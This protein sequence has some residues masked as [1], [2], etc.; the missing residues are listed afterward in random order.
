MANSIKT[1]LMFSLLVLGLPLFSQGVPVQWVGDD[2]LVNSD[3]LFPVAALLDEKN[4]IQKIFPQLSEMPDF[5]V[6]SKYL[7]F[8]RNVT[9]FDGAFYTIAT[10]NVEK[11][12]MG[13]SFRATSSP[14]GKMKLGIT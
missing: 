8:Q 11:K 14:N 6:Q 1:L 3:P 7:K 2:L 10:G 13:L 9:W 5:P 4:K 12:K